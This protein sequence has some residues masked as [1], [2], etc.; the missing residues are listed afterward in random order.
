M[1]S[2]AGDDES[3]YRSIT[4]QIFA[5]SAANWV[6][7]PCLT[8]TKAKAG[9]YVLQDRGRVDRYGGK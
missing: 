4:R 6:F 5:A 7:I 1:D 8:I 3:D 2:E 9:C